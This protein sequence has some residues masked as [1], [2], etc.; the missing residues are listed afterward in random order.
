LHL[1]FIANYICE[2]SLLEYSLLR[3]A[4]SL[5]AAS[6]VF[7]AKIVLIPTKSPWVYAAKLQ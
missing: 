1:E 5:I 6:S 2:L 4:P 7:L 3:Y